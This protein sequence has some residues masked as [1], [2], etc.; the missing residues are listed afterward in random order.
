LFFSL[1]HN[2]PSSRLIMLALEKQR[3]R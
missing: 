3:L 2:V 1:F